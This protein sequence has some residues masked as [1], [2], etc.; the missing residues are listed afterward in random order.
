MENALLNC[1][2]DMT[3]R[4]YVGYEDKDIPLQYGSRGLD[5]RL[6]VCERKL[7]PISES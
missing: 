6:Q 5:V 1:Y 7:Y 2:K 4:G 3:A